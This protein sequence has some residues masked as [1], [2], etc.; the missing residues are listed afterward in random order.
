[1]ARFADYDDP[2]T[3]NYEIEH[4]STYEAC[5][6][7]FEE[8]AAFV[9]TKNPDEFTQ[10]GVMVIYSAWDITTIDDCEDKDT[11]LYYLD[12]EIAKVVTIDGVDFDLI[13]TEIIS[14]SAGYGI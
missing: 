4:E 3:Y 1:M 13:D 10:D 14:V 2:A 9:A 8:A 5:F 12:D 7:S 6:D 11:A